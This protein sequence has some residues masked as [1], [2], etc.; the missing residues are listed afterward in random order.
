MS[1][2][3]PYYRRHWEQIEPERLAAY[4]EIFR[5]RPNMEPLIAGAELG[6]GQ[7]VVDYGCGPGFLAAEIARRVGPAGHVIGCDLNPEFLRRA[8]AR[9]ESEQLAVRVT[10]YHVQDDRVPLPDA[11]V[12]RVLCKN[13]LE[14]VPSIDAT[15]REFRRVL[16]RG[17]RAHAIDSDWYTLIVEPLGPDRVAR[18][19]AAARTAYKEPLAGRKL[20]GAFQQAGFRDVTAKVFARPDTRG[21]LLPIVL[22]MLEYAKAG[23]GL[24]AGEADAIAADCQAAVAAGTYLLFLP[25]FLV[26]GVVE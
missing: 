9:V 25:Q 3:A 13:V 26:T 8:R 19:L 15:L 17:G 20:Y 18:L 23:G 10:W 4:E 11:C 2:S 21:L 1:E 22:N 16:K 6:L 5:W 7:T 12:D 24:P 14:Y